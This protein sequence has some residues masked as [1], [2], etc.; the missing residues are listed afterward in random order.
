MA[1]QFKHTRKSVTKIMD[2]R[3]QVNEQNVGKKVRLTII[4]PGSPAQDVKTKDGQY[5]QSVVDPE[6]VAQK[7]IFNLNASSALA[8]KHPEVRQLSREGLA[9]ETAGNM[10]LAHEKYQAF[11]NATQISF[12]VFTTDRILDQLGDRVDIAAEIISVPG[13]NGNVLTI[14]PKTIQVLKP[15]ELKKV[16]FSFDE[17]DED[18]DNDQVGGGENLNTILAGGAQA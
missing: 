6:L 11:L 17:E 5:V 8:M 14:D 7:I 16:T 12:N 9:A 13:A 15:E 1:T 2:R 4:G 3:G 18:D 10:E